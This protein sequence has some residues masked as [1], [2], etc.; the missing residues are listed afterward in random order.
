VTNRS[1]ATYVRKAAPAGTTADEPT[2]PALAALPPQ[3]QAMAKQALKRIAAET[4]L[5]KLKEGIGQFDAQAAAAPEAM[6]PFIG[7]MKDRMLARI[8]ELEKG[9]APA[10]K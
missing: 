8:A 6:R 9:A 1:V 2:D 5:A 10:A 7:F 4:D 3:M